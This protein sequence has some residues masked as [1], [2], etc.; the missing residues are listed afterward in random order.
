MELR[1]VISSGSRRMAQ[2]AVLAVASAGLAG[3]VIANLPMKWV[4]AQSEAAKP[5]IPAQSTPAPPPLSP[6]PLRIKLRPTIQTETAEQAKLAS[7]GCMSCHTGIEHPNMHAE[8]TVV[9]GCT[10][11][12]GGNSDVMSTHRPGTDEYADEEQKAHVQPRFPED[13]AQGGHP[14][15][16]Y[17]RWLKES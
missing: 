13:L 7:V 15:R 17:V 4:F 10:D 6:E 8:D 11:C 5:V 3:A 16:P 12:H 14:V 1:K 2:W 9:L